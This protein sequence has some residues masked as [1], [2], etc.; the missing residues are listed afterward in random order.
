MNLTLIWLISTCTRCG[1]GRPGSWFVGRQ[2]PYNTCIQCR[3]Q[4]TPLAIAPPLDEMTPLDDLYVAASALIEGAV[5]DYESNIYLGDYL[6]SLSDDELAA[7][8]LEKVEI[9]DGYR[10][11]MSR[12]GN[13]QKR[14]I[15]N[16]AAY[17]CQRPERQHQRTGDGR[18]RLRLRLETYEC[19]G[20][21][22][23]NI[24][25][26]QNW[27]NLKVHHINHPPPLQQDDA[28][29]PQEVRDFIRQRALTTT[30]ADLCR[31][32]GMNLDLPPQGHKYITGVKKLSC[33]FTGW[34]TIKCSP[35]SNLSNKGCIKDTKR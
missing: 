32:F 23:G 24:D 30:C 14:S 34:M 8:I 11:T 31:Q 7:E 9:C 22:T 27:I 29:V 17:C 21:V 33:L 18:R 1:S 2:R 25:R 35:Q 6:H 26:R 10:Y 3:L 16:F 4:Q 13:L 12:V 15:I 19:N 20:H 28:T 5:L